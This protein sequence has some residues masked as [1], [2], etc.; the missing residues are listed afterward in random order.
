MLSA[1]VPSSKEG[2]DLIYRVSL[3]LTSDKS[4]ISAP[5]VHH[6]TKKE[7]DLLNKVPLICQTIKRKHEVVVLTDRTVWEGSGGEGVTSFCWSSKLEP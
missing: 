1:T 2:A 6:D 5:F 3:Y 4:P 7:Q